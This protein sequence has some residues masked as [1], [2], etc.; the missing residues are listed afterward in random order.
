MT[1][2]RTP[3]KRALWSGAYW[4]IALVLV[5]L[6]HRA[7]EAVTAPRT[8]PFSELRSLVETGK[9]ERAEIHATEIVARVRTDRPDVTEV[10]RALRLPQIDESGLIAE[11]DRRGARYQGRPEV[12]SW[13]QPL[14]F[15]WIVPF[16]L[17]LGLWWL[18]FHRAGRGGALRLGRARIAPA[19]PAERVTFA[20]V[21]GVDEAVAELREVVDFLARPERYRALG[22]RIPRG[23]LLVGPPGTGKTLLARAV[24]GEANVPFFAL[25][26]SE[27]VE[28]FAG[29]GAARARDLFEQARRHAPCI[30]FID[31]IDAIGKAR[32]GLVA[33]PAHDEREQTL[34]QLLAE[35]DGFE[36]TPGVVIIAA[37]NRPEILDPALRRPGR[38][39]RMIVVDRPDV[40]GREAI[41]RVHTRAVPLAPS[42]DLRVVAQRTAG[43]AGADL[44]N[45]VNEAALAAARRGA[46]AVEIVDLEAAID[47]LQLG[48]ERRRAMSD[49]DKC[50]VAVH[51]AGH[52]VVALAVE[53]ADPVHRVTII[54]RSIG[55]LG[56][57]LQLPDED[58]HLMS[59]AALL[60]RVAVLL[61][62]RCAEELLLGE[63]STGAE[64]DLERATE[65]ARAIV[66]RYGMSERLGPLSLDSSPGG[67]VPGPVALRHPSEAMASAI[68][69][70][71]RAVIEEQRRRATRL[72]ERH[73]RALD[74]LVTRLLFKET[75]ERDD[76]RAIWD[77]ARRHDAAAADPL[78]ATSAP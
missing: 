17:I 65:L 10:V 43:M 4:L 25:S 20:D 30:V 36:R 70:E 37:T 33:A 55:A 40:A 3:S 74:M 60:D 54:P 39:D 62:G 48:L 15:G 64:H 52:A 69:A 42:V 73:R 56:A 31:E 2:T 50:R 22:A 5:L 63:A 35:M 71:V 18:V 59:R 29:V 78:T 12:T 23:V 53:H 6:A 8:V 75:L 51:E 38:F 14:L 67:V 27:F 66:C 77:A 58:R 16:A 26:G 61:G 72:L 34:D 76:V 49:E 46:T 57:T 1:A 13:W 45:V 19:A 32:S 9:V 68:D 24:A 47:R 44:A 41:L 7:Y 21:A 11:L 28:L